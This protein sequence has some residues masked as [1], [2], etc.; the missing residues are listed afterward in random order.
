MRANR[1]IRGRNVEAMRSAGWHHQLIDRTSQ[2]ASQR[3]VHLLSATDLLRSDD[4]FEYLVHRACRL[5]TT[6]TEP[7]DLANNLI[8]GMS[9]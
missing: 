7:L 9:A 4:G 5:L 8:N 1:P 2:C 6:R 3:V